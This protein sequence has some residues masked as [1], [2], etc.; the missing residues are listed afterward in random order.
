MENDD[1]WAGLF[2][3]V[4]VALVLLLVVGLFGHPLRKS[5]ADKIS[6][7]YGGGLFEGNKFQKIV[8]PG[9]GLIFNGWYDKWYEYPTTQRN[10]IVSMAADEGDKEQADAITAPDKSGV[11]ENV[12]LTVTF[13]L[14]TSKKMIRKF[15]E[16]IGLKYKAWTESGW[17][18]ML[19]DNF[20]QP[21]NNAV[22]E[23]LREY[24]TDQIRTSPE[25]LSQVQTA[26]ESSLKKDID[27]L[28]GDQYFCGPSYKLGSTVCPNFEVNVKAITPPA[29]VIQS[30]SDQKTSQNKIVVAE[31]EAQAKIEQAKGEEAA[32]NAVSNALTPEYLNYLRVQALQTCAS[33][34]K[35]S[36]I[37]GGN[38]FN[39]N[40]PAN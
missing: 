10:Y 26:V 34:G 15:H 1:F 38:D 25:V 40:V 4:G 31:N 32:K 2:G 35:C 33:S 22:Q 17:N 18:K 30:Y 20:R 39:V 8:D 36:L 7:S 27:T 5:P 16:Q 21:L 28:M 14:N 6:L 29:D 23:K 24:T 11:A 9:S 13:K 12:E 19:A 37:V 3:V